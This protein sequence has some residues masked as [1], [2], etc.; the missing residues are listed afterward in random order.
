MLSLPHFG[1][2]PVGGG[3][4]VLAL[5]GK[6]AEGNPVP[7]APPDGRALEGPSAVRLP[8]QERAGAPEILAVVAGIERHEDRS[9]QLPDGI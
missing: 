3:A 9:E 1:N 6:G 8:A 4:E 2:G 5:V 7:P